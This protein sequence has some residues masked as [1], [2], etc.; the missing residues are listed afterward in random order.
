MAFEID[1]LRQKGLYVEV[2]NNDVNKAMRKLK[3]M[4]QSEGL[5]QTLRDRER[6]EKPSMQRK[7]AKVRAEKRWQKKLREM[8]TAGIAR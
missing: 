5:F 4:I 3:K 7:K 8:K 2:H 6:F 1:D